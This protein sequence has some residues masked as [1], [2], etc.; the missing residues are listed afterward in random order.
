MVNIDNSRERE[1]ERERPTV[2]EVFV[3]NVGAS[4]RSGASRVEEV[5]TL[6][7]VPQAGET[8]T[9]LAVRLPRAPTLLVG[10]LQHTYTH[11]HTHTDTYIRS[12][13]N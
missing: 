7:C 3:A 1:R 10:S 8:N 13:Q 2:K 12:H 5:R 11:T 9:T 6:P 4:I